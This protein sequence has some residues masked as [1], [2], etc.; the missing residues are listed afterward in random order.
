MPV[1]SIFTRTWVPDLL[2]AAVLA[3]AP[4][5]LPHIG[6]VPET[7]SRV[8]VW[9]LFG[10]GFD[11]LFGYTGLLSFGQAAFFGTGGFVAAYL[12]TAMGFSNAVLGLLIGMAAAAAAG[13]LVGLIALRRTGIYFTMITVAIAEV[14][15][16]I[17]NSPLS[18]YT[19][20]ENGLP[21][22]PAPVFNLGFTTIKADGTWPMYTFMAV[23][24][25]AGIM[26][27]RRIVRSPAGRILVAIRDNPIRAAATG[28]N[29][30][31]YKLLVF[32]IAAA[33][34]GLRGRSLGHSSRLYAARCLRLRYV[35]AGCHSDRNRRTW[36]D[37]RSA[38]RRGTVALSARFSSRP[39]W[40]RR[41]LEARSRHRLCASR[42]LPPARDRWRGTLCL[43]LSFQKR[44]VA[45]GA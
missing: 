16:F 17:E 36:N 10:I 14:F 38:S 27:A 24:Y 31:H 6:F 22:V 11:L 1:R 37:Y 5:V 33:Y 39:A 3:A 21:G 45:R 2:T 20:G 32:V 28:H 15:F 25:M 7:M 35:R 4:F 40:F 29:I 18:N 19:G 41:F 30:H 42:L 12:L 23:C 9:G 34:A 44:P 13:A 43:R 8:L 26:I